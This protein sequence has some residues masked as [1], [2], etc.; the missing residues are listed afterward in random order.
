MR[1]LKGRYTNFFRDR[2]VWT[3]SLVTGGSPTTM[4]EAVAEIVTLHHSAPDLVY[5]STIVE[6]DSP[7]GGTVVSAIDLSAHVNDA[8]DAEQD[9]SD[10][11]QPESTDRMGRA[12]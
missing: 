3:G 2:E 10:A 9:D 4:A 1:H 5:W 7:D 8:L 11:D 12:A 6:H